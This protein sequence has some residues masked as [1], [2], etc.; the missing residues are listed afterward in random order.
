MCVC[1]IIYK[2]EYN[3]YYKVTP[4][5]ITGSYDFVMSSVLADV[6][7]G[8]NLAGDDYWNPAFKIAPNTKIVTNDVTICSEKYAS[9]YSILTKFQLVDT[10]SRVTL[11]NVTSNMGV[12][13]A[14]SLETD[15]MEV[16][17]ECL[18]L[19]VRFPLRSGSME[20]GQWHMMSISV[21]QTSLSLFVDNTLVHNVD[22][23]KE[24]SC[25]LSC[26]KKEVVTGHSPNEVGVAANAMLAHLPLSPLKVFVQ[27]LTLVPL[28]EAASEQNLYT[29]GKCSHHRT[30]RQAVG[31]GMVLMVVTIYHLLVCV[32]RLLDFPERRA[33]R[34]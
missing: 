7:D 6:P 18:S 29:Y 22:I 23:D 24:Q 20:A 25:L 19:L 16:V 10:P 5:L 28:A 32:V 34:D 3:V 15:N 17:F 1:A 21:L 31:S 30:L 4:N 8:V 26:D 9:Q 33:P 13:L 12:E 2:V 11:L 14:V 27:Q